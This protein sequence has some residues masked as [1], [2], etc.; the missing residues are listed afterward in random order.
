MYLRKGM[1][2]YDERKAEL[3]AAMHAVRKHAEARP[4]CSIAIVVILGIGITVVIEAA[5]SVEVIIVLLAAGVH[6]WGVSKN[7]GVYVGP[8][9][10]ALNE[11]D[12]AAFLHRHL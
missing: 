8:S 9:E 2:I 1:T 4:L 12:E 10:A 11:G 6:F 5:I 3:D 7:A